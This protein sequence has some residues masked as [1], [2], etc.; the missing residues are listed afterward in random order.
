MKM[1]IIVAA[2]ALLGLG[3]ASPT[4]SAVADPAAAKC[5]LNAGPE[6]DCIVD[7]GVVG[8]AGSVEFVIPAGKVAFKGDLQGND[9]LK[10]AVLQLNQSAY[11]VDTGECAV[12]PGHVLC[13]AKS[14]TVSAVVEAKR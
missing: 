7:F 14:G 10:V 8:S 5:S 4:A 6:T 13:S 12:A 2:V 3:A 11:P 1:K 9:K